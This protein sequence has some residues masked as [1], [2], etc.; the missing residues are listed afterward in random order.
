MRRWLVP[1]ALLA[2]ACTAQGGTGVLLMSEDLVDDGYE[3]VVDEEIH[4]SALPVEALGEVWLYGPDGSVRTLEVGPDEVYD[5]YGEELADGTWPE[6]TVYAPDE[7]VGLLGYDVDPDVA[8]VRGRR[9]ALEELA[10]SMPSAQ[11]TLEPTGLRLHGSEILRELA[12]APD[13]SGLYE[14]WPEYVAVDE[15]AVPN[16]DP[17]PSPTFGAPVSA[18]TDADETS[19]GP[20]AFL[21][22]LFGGGETTSNQPVG[23]VTALPADLADRRP[24]VGFYTLDRREIALSLDGEVRHGDHDGVPL[25]TWSLDAEGRPV[26]TLGGRTRRAHRIFVTDLVPPSQEAP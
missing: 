2:G 15:P 20:L 1:M 17:A 10:A 6:G 5:V 14:T 22:A 19:N 23:T 8:W 4:S 25:G 3:W 11:A 24:H 7:P 21:T 18:E 9:D 13:I 16:A 12:W 26:V